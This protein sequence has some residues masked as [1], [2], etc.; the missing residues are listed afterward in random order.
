MSRAEWKAH[1]RRLLLANPF[2]EALWDEVL[3]TVDDSGSG[4]PI[5]FARLDE[6]DRQEIEAGS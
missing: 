1:V 6:D 4:M 3:T 5:L 2:D